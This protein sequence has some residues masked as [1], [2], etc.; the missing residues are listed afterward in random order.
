MTNK[1]KSYLSILGLLYCAIMLGTHYVITKQ[2]SYSMD[3]SMLTAYRFLIAAIPLY[4][5]LIYTKKNPFQ[6]LKP[7]VV[8][9]FFLWLVF[10]LISLGLRYTSAI[11]TGFISG[12][13]FVF[14]PFINYLI[15]KKHINLSYLPVIAISLFGLSLLTGALNHIG[16][17][18]ILILFS[19]IFTAIHLL[20]VGNYSKNGIDPVVICFQQ[21]MMVF[22]L[23]IIYALITN[24]LTLSITI[25]QIKPLIFLGLF[26]TLSV[27][28]VQMISLKKSSEITAAIVL[29]LQPGFATFF[30]CLFGQEKLMIFQWF[31]GILLFLSAIMYATLTKCKLNKNEFSSAKTK[32]VEHQLS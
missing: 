8:L 4:V 30:A 3:A 13:F 15:F 31:G 25:D 29:S 24:K 19:A 20:L 7:G 28:F 18:D 22:L 9:G 32:L 12:M 21:F 11:N 26:P 10:I 17:G 2:L 1:I 23:S 27:F 6:N 5:Y 16:L 14:V